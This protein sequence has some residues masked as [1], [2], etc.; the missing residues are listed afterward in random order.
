MRVRRLIAVLAS[1]ALAVTG[2]GVVA[3]PVSAAMT[4]SYPGPDCP[5]VGDH[6]LQDCVDNAA[7]GDT[8]V[9]T[10]QINPDAG[11]VIDKSLTLRATN[12]SLR[13]QLPIIGV[14]D[15][16]DNS[17]ANH[18]TLQDLVVGFGIFGNFDQ[19][20]GHSL[21]IR[22]VH[23]GDGTGNTSGIVINATGHMDLTVEQS[24]AR[25]TDHQRG[26]LE[27]YTTHAT[28]TSHVRAVGNT[29]TQ[30]GSTDSGSGVELE[31]TSSGTTKA[32]ID[33][34]KI[35]D[36]VQDDAGGAS[37]SSYTRTSKRRP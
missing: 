22:R 28:G 8:I 26:S 27:F 29:F 30:H 33:N 35:R 32:E 9:M 31:M 2:L 10:S 23:V 37:G 6:G 36:V 34:N 18:I 12:R 1:T 19:A 16:G 3:G 17:T 7:A 13:P 15:H 24:Y 4:Y 14:Y 20:S 5:A 11:V 25:T 21:T